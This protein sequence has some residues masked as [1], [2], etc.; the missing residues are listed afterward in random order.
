LWRA[1]EGAST[2]RFPSVLDAVTSVVVESAG[3]SFFLEGRRGAGSIGRGPSGLWTSDP[4]LVESI[5]FEPGARLSVETSHRE[6]GG[7][8]PASSDRAVP[9]GAVAFHG[10]IRAAGVSSC[11]LCPGGAVVGITSVVPAGRW[12][13]PGFRP[14]LFGGLHSRWA[15]P[16]VGSLSGSRFHRG[17]PRARCRSADRERARVRRWCLV[18]RCS[19]MS[20]TGLRGACVCTPPAGSANSVE[21]GSRSLGVGSSDP[22]FRT[23][24]SVFPS[25]KDHRVSR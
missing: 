19:R 20:G 10:L 5:R 21:R 6:Q 22:S 15:H 8:R 17:F 7:G 24:P 18:W 14:W 1:R 13:F 2:R 12:F 4:L 9:S 25:G 16:R 23:S 11:Q 3:G